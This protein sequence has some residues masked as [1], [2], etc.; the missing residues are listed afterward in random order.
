MAIRHSGLR[1]A[2]GNAAAIAIAASSAAAAARA[3]TAAQQS[4]SARVDKPTGFRFHF[5][6]ADGP[7]KR[8][9]WEW[10]ELRAFAEPVR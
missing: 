4:L 3:Q 6:P 2:I 1:S 9:D 5:G 10:T 8:V 7:V